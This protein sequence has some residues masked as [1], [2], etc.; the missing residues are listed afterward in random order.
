MI[1]VAPIVTRPATN[2]SKSQ[3]MIESHGWRVILGDLKHHRG[4]ASTGSV[5]GNRAQQGAANAAPTR[6]RYD[7]DGENLAF[8]SAHP[9][10]RKPDGH[11][12]IRHQLVSNISACAGCGQ[13]APK[14]I[15]RPRIIPRLRKACDVQCCDDINITD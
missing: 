3:A 8:L 1:I 2:G 11:I 6:I 13:N 5:T 4:C 12:D 7:A 10:Q 14:K 15:P 9:D